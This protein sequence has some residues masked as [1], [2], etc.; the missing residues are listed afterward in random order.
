MPK[1]V[2]SYYLLR[3]LLSLPDGKRRLASLIGLKRE[4]L[5]AYNELAAAPQFRTL[6]PRT[7][8]YWVGR[9]LCRHA[10][11]E[12]IGSNIPGFH[13]FLLPVETWP[14][15]PDLMLAEGAAPPSTILPVVARVGAST[16]SKSVSVGLH[17]HAFFTDGLK[18]VRSALEVNDTQP[19]LY[20]TGP[21][22]NR[23]AVMNAFADYRALVEFIPCANVGRDVVPFLTMLPKMRADGHGLIGHIHI[24]GA[25]DAALQGFV[26]HWSRFLLSSLIGD[27][28]SGQASID[29]IVADLASAPVMPTLYIPQL[30][31]A[32]G[33]GPNRSAATQ[34]FRRLH[35]GHLPDRFLFSAGTMFW[36]T[37]DYLHA[38]EAL[39]L[40][41]ADLTPEPLPSDGTV[42]HA[43]ERLFG[44]L[45]A[46]RGDRV[47]ICPSS[48]PTFIFSPS[49]MKRLEIE[50]SDCR[51]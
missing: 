49:L 39:D 43:V 5:A 21:H 50:V 40:P 24:K 46:A 22:T 2:P 51:R 23:E 35:H 33:W 38:F 26:Q 19:Q 13:P 17:I 20:V 15:F 4:V 25:L 31:E 32:I 30:T 29:N 7:R 37:P 45:A 28:G 18:T 8:R 6:P 27:P 44:A 3:L 11:G 9:Q 16:F 42:L 12:D 36:A 41:W 48:D 10:S 47:A 34:L 14:R 1:R